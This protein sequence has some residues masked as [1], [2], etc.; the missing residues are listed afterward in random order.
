MLY[1]FLLETI[2]KRNIT[3][4]CLLFNKI[5]T[6]IRYNLSPSTW[7][8][9]NSPFKKINIFGRNKKIKLCFTL[10]NIYES[11]YSDEML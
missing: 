2:I 4:K 6:T 11:F 5:V 8:L 1:R 7:E 3:E 10:V 9:S